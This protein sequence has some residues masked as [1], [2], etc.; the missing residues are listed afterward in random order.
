MNQPNDPHRDFWQRA[1]RKM[2]LRI[3]AGFVIQCFLPV[4][5][6]LSLLQGCLLLLFRKLEAPTL[7][8]WI[9]G[10]VAIIFSFILC[11]LIARRR[12]YSF[13]DTL[14]YLEV[15]LL[16]DNRLTT[17]H[18]KHGSWPEPR[19]IPS[20]LKWSYRRLAVPP[21]ASIGFLLL[22][23]SIPVQQKVE[24]QP[25]TPEEPIA[26]Q[27]IESW[28]ETLEERDLFEEESIEKW[29]E[30]VEALREQPV[31]EW[32]SHNSLEAGDNLRDNVADSIRQM[33]NK[34]DQAAY[35][36]VVA[37]DSLDQMPS[38]LAP[39]LDKLW[40]EALSDLQ[41]GD[42]K[43]NSEMLAQLQQIDF[44]NLQGISQEQLDR[45]TKML[46]E[47][48]QTCEMAL[49][50]EPCNNPGEACAICAGGVCLGGSIASGRPGPDGN[51]ADLTFKESPPLIDSDRREAVSNDDLSHAALG[52]EIGTSQTVPEVD[53]NLPLG[54]IAAG[55]ANTTSEG[56]EAVFHSRL[57][58]AE[59]ARLQQYFR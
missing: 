22:A 20:F 30:Q 11:G 51:S 38:G 5:V 8:L 48:M 43:L 1:A 32:Y 37:R 6:G 44:S 19:P 52:E 3:N 57:T 12:F 58:P 26:W 23:G 45:L 49:N 21:L 35:P 53:P 41:A 31:Q 4:L 9:A 34:L 14:V 39:Q 16:L 54:P 59:E 15:R 28:A 10:G 25:L 33:H 56:G 18:K 29:K 2:R 47:S 7:P 13:A 17:A 50:G 40:Q 24:A 55:A 46:S 36:L 27:Q 42:L